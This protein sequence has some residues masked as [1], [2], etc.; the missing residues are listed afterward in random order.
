MTISSQCNKKSSKSST[1]AQEGFENTKCEANQTVKNAASKARAIRL[2]PG[3]LTMNDIINIDLDVEI[4]NI[5]PDLNIELA[6]DAGFDIDIDILRDAGYEFG[7][8][9]I[10]DIDLITLN[11]IGFNVNLP[12]IDVKISE[13][14]LNIPDINFPGIDI[15]G[16]D[17]PDPDID[18]D[19]SDIKK[20]GFFSRKQINC[21][22]RISRMI[23][24]G[25]TDKKKI[26]KK[27]EK[28]PDCEYTFKGGNHNCNSRS[29]DLINKIVKYI[30]IIFN[31][32]VDK[33]TPW[34]SG[35]F[36]GFI[37]IIL[38][39]ILLNKLEYEKPEAKV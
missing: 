6:K 16:I 7:D 11:K 27:C 13:W 17:I 28:N 36:I 29:E 21:P 15:P 1:R 5:N 34:A 4:P 32:I 35:L 25:V 30:N 3:E 26:K 20:P 31:Y 14:K 9:V 23:K 39:N 10:G 24:N 37:L 22:I 38:F 8:I 12:D 33:I 2:E 19:F 18:L